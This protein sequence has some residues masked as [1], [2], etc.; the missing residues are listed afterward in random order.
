M[1]QKLQQMTTPRDVG[2]GL[3]IVS[4]ILMAFAWVTVALRVCVRKSVKAYG[5]DDTFMAG[6]LVSAVD[7]PHTQ[8]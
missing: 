6:G 4:S 5:L 1:F 8:R 3:A 7:K 2:L